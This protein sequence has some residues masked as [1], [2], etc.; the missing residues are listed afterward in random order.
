MIS[1]IS[2]EEN[3]LLPLSLR[4]LKK[5]G[6][7]LAKI[8]GM[9]DITHLMKRNPLTLSGGE[10]QRVAMARAAINKP[11]FIIADEPT[12]NLDS[13]NSASVIRLMTDLMIESDAGIILATHEQDLMEK[14]DFRYH[15][16][17][18]MINEE[19]EK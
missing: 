16:K 6:E 1:E 4:N 3:I 7:W 12:G 5:D 15:L 11:D 9:L 17:D 2:V 10:K 19:G 18:G 8:T 14:G 13:D